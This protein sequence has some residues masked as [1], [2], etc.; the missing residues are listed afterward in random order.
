MN[1]KTDKKNWGII[2][3]DR[4]RLEYFDP[5]QKKSLN[6]NFTPN[7]IRD[8]EVVNR[9]DLEVQL[10]LFINYYKIQPG[11]L[12]IILSSELCFE[13]DIMEANESQFEMIVNNFLFSLPFEETIHKTYKLARGYK[14]VAVNKDLLETIK[15][16]FTKI[17]FK[18]LAIVPTSIVGISVKNL[19]IA[20][21]DYLTAKWDFIKDHTM[22]VMQEITPGNK[23][24]EKK[25]FGINRVLIFLIIFIFLL[26]MLLL[27]LY[28]QVGVKLF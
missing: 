24:E 21:A 12:V 5:I 20:S 15:F 7:L 4:E 25:V 14:I 16:I 27:M 26:L 11:Q 22:M 6:F 17:G 10:I 13:K 18:T 1:T 23:T 28:Q 9:N 8:F 3:M 19:D 2:F